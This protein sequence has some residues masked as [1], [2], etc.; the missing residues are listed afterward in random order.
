MYRD[1]AASWSLVTLSRP[2]SAL[3]LPSVR[4]FLP[5]PDPILT[6]AVKFIAVVRQEVSESSCSYAPSLF[7]F[8]FSLHSCFLVL[9][10]VPAKCVSISAG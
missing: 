9:N 1:Y 5:R 2:L 8:S 6:T 7:L 10:L 4:I 3:L